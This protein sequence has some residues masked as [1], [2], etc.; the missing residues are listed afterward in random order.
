MIA[1][2]VSTG[3]SPQQPFFYNEDGDLSH[4]LTEA[5]S[6]DYPDV[7]STG[8]PDAFEAYAPPS[9]LN[10]KPQTQRNGKC[11]YIKR[12]KLIPTR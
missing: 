12:I 11:W 2:V 8:A 10:L 7:E 4:L 5:T 3:C 6:I 1:T 9:L